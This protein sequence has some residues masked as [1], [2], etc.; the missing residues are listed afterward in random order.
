MSGCAQISNWRRDGGHC[1]VAGLSCSIG[2]A[3]VRTDAFVR[4]AKQALPTSACEF[5]S[6]KESDHVP[7]DSWH[8]R[9]RFVC[10]LMGAVL[11]GWSK[12][13]T[14]DHFVGFAFIA[15]FAVAAAWGVRT[16]F[17]LGH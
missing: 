12:G 13:S 17:V 6:G 2:N 10:R 11:Q 4:P 8:G 14:A 5:D 15:V 1:W 7:Q 16:L 3:H 9:N